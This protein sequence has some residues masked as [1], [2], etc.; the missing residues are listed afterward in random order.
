MS[1]DYN[2]D[3]Q[4]A[5]QRTPPHSVEAEQSVLGSLMLDERA[6]ETVAETLQDND[7]YRHDH[8][9]IFRAIQHLVAQEQPIDVV[10][11][12]EE[13]EER[14]QLEKAGGP[15]YLSRLVDMTPSIDNC[16]AYA[17]IVRERSQQR[18]LIE[19]ATDIM[20]RAY[21]TE[22]ESSLT[23]I[24]DAEKAIALIAEGS[25]KDGG[26][27]AVGPILKNTLETLERMFE[28]PDGLTG[29]TTG[30]TEIDARTS[31]LQKADLVIVAARPSMGKT[32]YS[33]N[34]VENALLATKRPCLV[35]SMEMPSESIVMRMLSSIG[36][37]DQTRIRSG[38]LIDED[39]P[40]LSAAV[41]L[42][43][44][45]PLYIDDT[46]ALTP[47]EMR[48]R[49]RK[50]YRENNND[51]AMIM[52]D[53]LQLMRVSGK[54]EGR[55]QEISEISRTLKAIAKEFNC[56]M[57]ALSQLNR[58]LEQRPNK[59][60]VMSDLRES[61]AIEQDADIIQFIYRDEVYNED[62]PDKGV[63]EIIT[64]KHRNG[65]IGID[66]LAFIG[67]YTRFE[68]LARGYEGG[69]DEY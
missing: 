45:L 19:A 10:T 18:R 37:I 67:K 24:S 16:A 56:P 46:P 32:T 49:A 12:S 13:L 65:P 31:G 58:S 51:L 39:W 6:W 47:Q 27:Q 50:V 40:K 68:N 25:R 64:G 3:Q 44:D 17:E 61:G 23:L 66:R 15:G 63:A 52:V 54:S 26:P 59:R 33:M 43:K 8:R 38:K 34:L 48:A 4:T 69:D 11:V 28:Q 29:L 35:F 5:S 2:S 22:G 14:A 62:S 9:L 30:F 42:L 1:D 20:Q 57:I 55:T 41:N 60:P 53:Y 36:K 21:E 7:F